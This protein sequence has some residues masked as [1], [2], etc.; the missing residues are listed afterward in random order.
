[1]DF[2]D[3]KHDMVRC[4]NCNEQILRN[5]EFILNNKTICLGCAVERGITQIMDLDIN[6]KLN[7]FK[8]T[9]LGDNDCHYCYVISY[10]T[11]KKLGYECTAAGSWFK[12]TIYPNVL[13]IYE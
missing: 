5:R 6:H 11:M 1:M 4:T 8:K 10:S 7:C 2:L 3:L 13:V 9:G 12:R